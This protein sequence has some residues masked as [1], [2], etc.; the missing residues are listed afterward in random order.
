MKEKL[1]IFDVDGVLLDLWTPMKKVFEEY[2]QITLTDKA[3]D[4]IV[5]DYLQ[6]PFPYMEFGRFFDASDTIRNLPP[7]KGMPK[8]VNDLKAQGFDLA[9]ITSISNK[10]EI[11]NKRIENLKK[12]YGDVF[13]KL[14][15]V[16]RGGS[17]E[18][19]LRDV[20]ADYQIS[21]FCDD[22]PKNAL[23]SKGIVTK[24][25]WFENKYQRHI[26]KQIDHSGIGFV[27]SAEDIYVVVS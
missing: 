22:H 25:L 7:I 17:K 27:G 18:Q 16:E 24:P 2:E 6:N 10:E 15:C 21:F 9:I 1:F 4:N 3:W 11:K 26:W 8:L 12:F 13:D 5:A 20:A 14:I 19:A 23:L